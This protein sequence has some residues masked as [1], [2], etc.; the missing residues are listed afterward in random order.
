MDQIVK[1]MAKIEAQERQDALT[2]AQANASVKEIKA[3]LDRVLK[4]AKGTPETR[5]A[6]K[7]L[8]RAM[9]MA[10]YLPAD[11]SI[12]K[13]FGKAFDALLDYT[14]K[15]IS[16]DFPLFGEPQIALA[17]R[18]KEYLSPKK[19]ESFEDEVLKVEAK[20]RQKAA[21][22][23][24]F[25][26]NYMAGLA[27]KI[28]RA[29]PAGAFE[30]HLSNA[31]EYAAPIMHAPSISKESLSKALDAMDKMRPE[32][33]PA[34]EARLA[35][36]L[37]GFFT[38]LEKNADMDMVD[39]IQKA[40]DK[41]PAE[42]RGDLT[43]RMQRAFDA[44][45]DAAERKAAN[46]S[47]HSLSFSLYGH[48]ADAAE[49]LE[50]AEKIAGS[51]LSQANQAFC[52]RRKKVLEVTLEETKKYAALGRMDYAERGLRLAGRIAEAMPPQEKAGM[53][54]GLTK[55]FAAAQQAAENNGNLFPVGKIAQFTENVQG[56][57]AALKQPQL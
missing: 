49:I 35:G 20:A 10:D 55:I 45:L 18:I 33:R 43:S 41:L 24:T 40:A 32:Q 21:K 44:A 37:D 4:C 31:E 16:Q 17:L 9:D 48:H 13:A 14:N 25:G 22:D 27:N 15:S 8:Q 38:S 47:R 11:A 56:K 26:I 36:A 29:L 54:P 39:L 46:L 19:Q 42:K 1:A 5:E 2:E 3:S 51:Y 52:D 6:S 28:K 23:K 53:E 34:A 57:I 30:Y 12:E 50:V 7:H